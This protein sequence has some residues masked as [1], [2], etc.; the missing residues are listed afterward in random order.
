MQKENII[1][2]PPN[3]SVWGGG[4]KGT[5]WCWEDPVRNTVFTVGSGLSVL[6]RGQAPLSPW[7]PEERINL[8]GNDKVCNFFLLLPVLLR[9]YTFKLRDKFN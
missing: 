3:R 2:D 1:P 7:S 6:R 4:E 5:P 8:D 9:G